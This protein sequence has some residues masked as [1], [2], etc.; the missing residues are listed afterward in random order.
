MFSAFDLFTR[1]RSEW[2][3][4]TAP[5][6]LIGE[7]GPDA[8]FWGNLATLVIV[9]ALAV[10]AYFALAGAARAGRVSSAL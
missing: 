8:V 5:R 7:T 9:G 1:G 6:P 2:Q 4:L 3:L 10:W